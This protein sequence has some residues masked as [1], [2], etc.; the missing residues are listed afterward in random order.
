LWLGGLNGTPPGP[1]FPAISLFNKAAPFRASSS[2][3]FGE[4]AKSSVFGSVI[5][6]LLWL[7]VVCS[8]RVFPI[9]PSVLLSNFSGAIEVLSYASSLPLNTQMPNK[10]RLIA[11]H[12][13]MIPTPATEMAFRSSYSHLSYVNSTK[14]AID[15]AI[16]PS[17]TT[18]PI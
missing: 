6:I 12:M 7:G 1:S 4:T 9:S 16:N 8:T 18:A 10:A 3:V 17:V 11:T 15:N 2:S 5:I 14:C 13:T